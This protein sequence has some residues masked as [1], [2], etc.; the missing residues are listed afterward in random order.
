MGD[1]CKSENVEL[2][3]NGIIR[4]DS[5]T[6]IGRLIKTEDLNKLKQERREYKDYLVRLTDNIAY[7]NQCKNSVCNVNE[8]CTCLLTD[9]YA[10]IGKDDIK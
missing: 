2:Q 10:Y 7:R 5:G 6:I 8:V 1:I 4:N 9:I 3:E